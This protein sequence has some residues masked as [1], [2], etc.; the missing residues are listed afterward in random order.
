MGLGLGLGIV[1]EVYN[2]KKTYL[3]TVTLPVVMNSRNH[4]VWL[5][6]AVNCNGEDGKV[7]V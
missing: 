3:C 4:F 5:P 1:Y 6:F 2:N 7:V